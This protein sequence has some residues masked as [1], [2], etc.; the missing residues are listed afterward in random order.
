MTEN[1]LKHLPKDKIKELETITER[2]KETGMVSMIILYGSYARGD[3]KEH[4]GGRSGKR[5]DYD[6]LVLTKDERDCEDLNLKL[7][8]MFE[9]FPTVVQTI[10]ETFGYVNMQLREKQYFFTEIKE[11]GIILYTDERSELAEAENLTPTRLREIAEYDYKEWFGTAEENYDVAEYTRNK[12][13]EKNNIKA[14]KKAAFELQ[15]CVEN[16]Y[17]AIEMVYSRNNPYEHRLSILRMNAQRYVPELDKCFPENTDE[18]RRLFFHL[19]RAYIGG[20]YLSEEFYS[21]T[22][23]Q[24]EY[25]EKEVKRLLEITEDYCKKRINE[26]KEKELQAGE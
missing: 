11:Q 4:V 22:L 18:E 7:Q 21:V 20:R 19:D 2:I 9:N 25:W 14:G 17:T 6:L 23:E 16:C 3:W 1:D 10:V 5:S 12:F 13:V 24:L 15:Q 8:K 26:L